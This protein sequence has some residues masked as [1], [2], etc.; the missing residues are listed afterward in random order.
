MFIY[1]KIFDSPHYIPVSK[2]N[3]DTIEI[4]IRNHFGEPILL[5]T[6]EVVVQLHFQRKSYYL[7]M[8]YYEH[9]KT[10]G[11]DVPF[12]RGSRYQRGHGSGNWFKSFYRF[13]VLF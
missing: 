13:V 4:D 9:F 1:S 8:D 7:I 2:N 10:G 11:S 5:K 12:F 6:G 3:I